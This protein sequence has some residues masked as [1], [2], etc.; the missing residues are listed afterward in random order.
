MCTLDG[1]D[2]FHG[3]GMMAAVTPATSRSTPVPRHP[4]SLEEIRTQD[5]R[6]L[7]FLQANQDQGLENLSY[8][9]LND[10]RCEDRDKFLDLAWKV[11][12]PLRSP[13]VGW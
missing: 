2:T 4:V 7:P 11:S 1:H 13:R 6:S 3:M 9:I 12:W 10:L 5:K 8:N